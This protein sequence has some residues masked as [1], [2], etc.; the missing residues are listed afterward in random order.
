MHKGPGPWHVEL[1]PPSYPYVFPETGHV[2]RRSEGQ[3]KKKKAPTL[4]KK[5]RDTRTCFLISISIIIF[6][7]RLAHQTT[8][9]H[10]E[11]IS[12]LIQHRL[13]AW[14]TG[15]KSHL[16]GVELEARRTSP[17][18][19]PSVAIPAGVVPMLDYSAYTQC[20]L[21]LGLSIVVVDSAARADRSSLVTT[22][23]VLGNEKCAGLPCFGKCNGGHQRVARP[24]GAQ[25]GP[26]TDQRIDGMTAYFS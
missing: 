19:P 16:L 5:S 11:M 26:L 7:S 9:H 12:H 13:K 8:T 23:S 15:R 21:Y 22:G 2:R 14:I 20:S 24:L 17:G 18:A 25:S 4:L 6:R 1:L 3:K 10:V